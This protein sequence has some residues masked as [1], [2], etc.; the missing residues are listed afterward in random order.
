MPREII[1]KPFFVSSGWSGKVDA[2]SDWLADAV[3]GAY[4]AWVASGA[5]VGGGDDQG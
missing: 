4:A 1:N 3:R 5:V 2:M